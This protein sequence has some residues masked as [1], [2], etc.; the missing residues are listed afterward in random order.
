[1]KGLSAKYE[2]PERDPTLRELTGYLMKR[3]FL[4]IR[5]GLKKELEPLG[6]RLITFSILAV[7]SDNPGIT[8][9]LLAETLAVDRSN[10][11]QLVNDLIHDGH[12][13]RKVSR[14]DGRAYSLII[15]KSGV[16]LLAKAKLLVQRH[17]DERLS[18]LSEPEISI[19]RQALL[20]IEQ[21]QTLPE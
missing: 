21:S 15:T 4:S 12:L 9:S 14:K 1:M 7:V 3:A 17:E 13:S 10:M 2:T 20:K 18:V 5:V 8:Q 6:L 11:A 16:E 19:L